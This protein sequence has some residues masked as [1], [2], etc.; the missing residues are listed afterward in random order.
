MNVISKLLGDWKFE[1]SKL[2]D[3]ADMIKSTNPETS[4]WGDCEGEL[5]VAIGKNGNQQISKELQLFPE[6]L[7]F[8]GEREILERTVVRQWMEGPS[9]GTALFLSKVEFL[10]AFPFDRHM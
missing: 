7:V 1:F 6:G 10:L 4:C 2:L 3:Y 5:L 9:F 8:D